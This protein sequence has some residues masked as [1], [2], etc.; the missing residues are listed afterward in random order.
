LKI[1]ASAGSGNT[2]PARRDRVVDVYDA[3]KGEATARTLNDIAAWFLDQD[4]R[5]RGLPREPGLLS[6]DERLGSAGPGP[7]GDARRETLAKLAE[8]QSN[9]FTPGEHRRAAV[10]VIDD[11]GQTSEAVVNLDV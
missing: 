5:R 4:L 10:R 11:S 2:R 7:Q 1:I 9:P 3:G 8:F 6:Q